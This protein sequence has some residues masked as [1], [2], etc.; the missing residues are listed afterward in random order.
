MCPFRYNQEFL[1]IK[2]NLRTILNV[3]LEASFSTKFYNFC[4]LVDFCTIESIHF[5]FYFYIKVTTQDKMCWASVGQKRRVERGEGGVT[6]QTQCRVIKLNVK[7]SQGWSWGASGCEE[8]V[9]V[10]PLPPCWKNIKQIWLQQVCFEC[11]HHSPCIHRMTK[12][13]SQVPATPN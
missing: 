5:S 3:E 6:V 11:P 10:S 12:N 4:I 1:M 9:L 13:H 7:V 2:L 8:D